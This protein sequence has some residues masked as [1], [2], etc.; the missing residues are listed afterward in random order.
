MHICTHT[1]TCKDICIRDSFY[2]HTIQFMHSSPTKIPPD[3]IPSQPTP[4][5][6]NPHYNSPLIYIMSICIAHTHSAK[7]KRKIKKGKEITNIFL[8]RAVPFH[9]FSVKEIKGDRPWGWMVSDSWCRVRG[10]RG[11]DLGGHRNAVLSGA[12]GNSGH[13][14]GE[15]RAIM[16]P[17][18][19]TGAPVWWRGSRARPGR[20]GPVPEVSGTHSCARHGRCPRG[21]CYN[22]SGY[23]QGSVPSPGGTRCSG[24][25]VPRH[26]SPPVC[27]WYDL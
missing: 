26:R 8:K 10:G 3:P 12:Q 14:Q 15:D 13:R 7:R 20:A 2:P 11:V 5:L 21:S 27:C 24:E 16:W 4:T 23:Q 9:S 17:I 18:L 19:L 1:H 22:C 6:P 25:V